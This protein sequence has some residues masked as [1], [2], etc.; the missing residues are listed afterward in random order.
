MDTAKIIIRPERVSD[1]PEIAIVQARAFGNRFAEPLIVALLRQ[2]RAFDQE[3]SLVAECNGRIV[4]HALFSSHQ[5]RLLDQSI[6][7]VNL[8]PIAVA[9][10]Y[11]GQR[12]G[13]QLITG[14]HRVAAVKGYK[15]SI[16]IGHPTYYPRSQL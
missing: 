4:G 9:P 8:A 14:G 1:Y 3:L 2:R 16:L 5:M 10:A 13:G 11:Q 15:V 7:T 12:I 6:P